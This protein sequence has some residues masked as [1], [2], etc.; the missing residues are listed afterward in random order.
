[1]PLLGS[2]ARL[3][4]AE[5][6]HRWACVASLWLL[7]GLCVKACG[8]SNVVMSNLLRGRDD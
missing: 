8:V 2:K 5:H 6:H 3:Q 7:E 4:R 1:M